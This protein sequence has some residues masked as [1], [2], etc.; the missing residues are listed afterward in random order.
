MD[1][2]KRR[3]W[4]RFI[5]L[6]E[7]QWIHTIVERRGFE[8]VRDHFKEKLRQNKTVIIEEADDW[9]FSIQETGS[10][11]DGCHIIPPWNATDSVSDCDHSIWL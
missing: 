4:G 2:P 5:R 11:T 7:L 10:F 1:E 6:Y 9:I 3:N 8:T